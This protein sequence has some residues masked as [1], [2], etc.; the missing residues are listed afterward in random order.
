MNIY[1]SH[2][3]INLFS[4]FD[5][6]FS[7]FWRNYCV[8]GDLDQSYGY[9]KWDC[10]GK[11]NQSF[12]REFGHRTSLQLP[13]QSS[14]C[15]VPESRALT[16][17]P[18]VQFGSVH[19]KSLWT[20]LLIESR[21]HHQL[22]LKTAPWNLA[23]FWVEWVY[24]ALCQACSSA[25]S[26]GDRQLQVPRCSLSAMNRRLHLHRTLASG[27]VRQNIA[28]KSTRLLFQKYH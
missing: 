19:S 13:L 26:H 2:K 28:G 25:K 20:F 6:P 23:W 8:G 7:T 22:H 10:K 17:S 16:M 3:L 14:S 27:F 18:A 1:V 21:S 12:E 9:G 11:D 24:N 15:S 4:T 5:I